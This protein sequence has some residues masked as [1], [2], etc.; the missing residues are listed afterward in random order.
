MS[1][2]T[3]K[4]G[5]NNGSIPSAVSDTGAT[6][7]AGTLHDPFIHS[8]TRSTKI[9]MNHHSHNPSTAPPQ[10]V[11]LPTQSTLYQTFTKHYSVVA[12]SRPTTQ[13]LCDK[14]SQLQLRHY[15]HHRTRSP[16]WLSMPTHRPL[17][18]P[19]PSI[20]VNENT[21][22]LIL[23]SK[24]GLQSTQPDIMYLHLHTSENTSSLPTMQHRP[25]TQCS[26]R[27]LHA[28]AGFPT[29]ST[30]L[31]AIRKGNYSTWPLIT[32]KTS[33][34]TFLNLRNTTGT[35]EEPTSRHKI[36]QTGPSP[37]GTS[38]TSPTTT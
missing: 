26:I 28:A 17:A 12:N 37:S 15:Q 13:P 22:T 3:I 24:C 34:N 31:A 1:P 6:S 32:V 21:D 16:H 25:Y 14:R 35:H 9:F 19:T 23:D 10:C 8:K 33:T 29:K 5:I 38:Y 30:W 20:T 4:E 7:T 27:Y 11:R 36:H 18:N 2:R